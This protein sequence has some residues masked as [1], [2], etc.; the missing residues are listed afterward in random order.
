MRF[1]VVVVAKGSLMAQH[2]LSDI[3]RLSYLRYIAEGRKHLAHMAMLDTHLRVLSCLVTDRRTWTIS[4]LADAT[5]LSRLTVRRYLRDAE[6]KGTVE[7]CSKG[8]YR[9]TD[10]G[11]DLF[12]VSFDEF[13]DR[14]KV[15]L[16]KF[17][18]VLAREHPELFGGKT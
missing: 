2:S 15:P 11:M 14:V 7:K 5:G 4:A 13:F 12:R 17:H 18:R 6:E 10:R 9:I 1:N 3:F 16:I 8:G